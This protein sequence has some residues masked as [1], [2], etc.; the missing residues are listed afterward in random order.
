MRRRRRGGVEAWRRGAC[1]K[2]R[3]KQRKQRPKQVP[4]TCPG[5]VCGVVSWRRGGVGVSFLGV[6]TCLSVHAWWSSLLVR[7]VPGRAPSQAN[8]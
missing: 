6:V 4:P 1:R 7:V 8:E 5:G 2:Q 3:P